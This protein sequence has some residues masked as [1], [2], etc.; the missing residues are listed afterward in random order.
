MEEKK[1]YEPPICEVIPL[2]PP[3]ILAES[4]E[5]ENK[6]FEVKTAE[7]EVETDSWYNNKQSIKFD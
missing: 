1:Q 3:P 5:A 4:I 6:E 2:T 7:Y